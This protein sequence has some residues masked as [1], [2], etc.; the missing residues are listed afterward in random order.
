MHLPPW[1]F[2]VFQY[3]KMIFGPA[4]LTAVNLRKGALIASPAKIRWHY[5]RTWFIP[6][7]IVTVIDMI[8]EFLG[9]GNGPSTG[10]ETHT[11]LTILPMA[12]NFDSMPSM[13]IDGYRWYPRTLIALLTGHDKSRVLIGV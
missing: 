3:A 12:L 8:L 5:L 2:I 10:P 13:N 1:Y 6:D 7:L 9:Q 4:Q 11:T